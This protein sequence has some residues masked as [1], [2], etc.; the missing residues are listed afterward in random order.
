MER[1]VKT[2]KRE[3]YQQVMKKCLI[4]F[5]A[6]GLILTISCKKEEIKPLDLKVKEQLRECRSCSGSWDLTDTIP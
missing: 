6:T 4:V 1:L 5:V 2:L 3:G